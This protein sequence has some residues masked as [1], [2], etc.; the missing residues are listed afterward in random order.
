MTGSSA[1]QAV[2]IAVA[3]ALVVGVPPALAVR[4]RTIVD[5]LRTG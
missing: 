1:A 3:L 4:R 5:G 2:G